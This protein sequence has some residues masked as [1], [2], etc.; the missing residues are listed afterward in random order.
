MAANERSF[1]ARVASA[2]VRTLSQL[3]RQPTRE[4][5]RILRIYFGDK[6]YQRLHGLALQ[7][8]DVRGEVK[9]LGNV[10]VLHGMLGGELTWFPPGG[11]GRDIWMNLWRIVRG[12][13]QYCQLKREGQSER[14]DIRATGLLQRYY[15]ELLLSLSR[16]WNVRPFWFDWRKDIRLSAS[17]L[18]SQIRNWFD[19]GQPVHLVAHS[20]GGLVARAFI[21]E[22]RT[23]WLGMAE[24]GAKLIMLGTPNFGSFSAL[25][26]LTGT[27]SMVR[28]VAKLDLCHSL[29]QIRAIASSFPGV[30][31]MLPWPEA[32][33]EVEAVYNSKNWDAL[34]DVSTEALANSLKFQEWLSD[35]IDP[36]RMIY[37]A[38]CNKPTANRLADPQAFW[39]SDFVGASNTALYGFTADGDGTVPHQLGFQKQGR[40]LFKDVY[41][42]EE[43]HGS[44]PLNHR[45][46]KAIDEILEEGGTQVL[47]RDPPS[48]RTA[49]DEEEL[50]KEWR[51][52]REPDLVDPDMAWS[53]DTPARTGSRKSSPHLVAAQR[54][55]DARMRSPHSNEPNSRAMRAI[56]NIRNRTRTATSL[57]SIPASNDERKVES[58][59]TRSFLYAEETD[60]RAQAMAEAA[61][62]RPSIEIGLVHAPIESL[63]YAS[64]P[65][66]EDLAVDCIS[67]GHY[68]GVLPQGAESKLDEAI[69]R[70]LLRRAGQPLPGDLPERDRVL[71]QYTERGILQGRL[72]QPFFLSDPRNH[73]NGTERLIVL[74]GMGVPGQ[75][76]IPELTVLVRELCWSLGQ[77]DKKHLL[78]VLI[79]GGVGNLSTEDAILGWM[80]GLVQALTGS[81]ELPNRRLQRVTFIEFDPRRLPSLNRAIHNAVTTFEESLEIK[82]RELDQAALTKLLDEAEK[83]EITRLR[84]RWLESEPHQQ[85]VPTRISVQ[86]VGDTYTFGAIT[87]DASIPQRNIPLDTR[88]VDDANRQLARATE[89]FEQWQQGR[90]LERLL[91]PRDF[92]PQMATGAP[93]VI[94]LDR[95]TA[96]LH[97]ELL[98]QPDPLDHDEPDRSSATS[99]KQESFLGTARGLTRQFRTAF[100]PPPEPPPPPRLVLRVLVIADPAEDARLPGAEREGVEVADLIES[101][102]TVFARQTMNR[103]YVERLFGPFEATWDNVLKKLLLEKWDVLHFAGHCFFDAKEPIRSGWIFGAKDRKVLTANEFNRIDS[104]PKFVFSN[105]CESGLMPQQAETADSSM[106]PSFAEAFFQRGVANF[107]CTAWP[108]DDAAACAFAKRL[109]SALLGLQEPD[110]ARP[111]PMHEAMRLARCEI[112]MFGGHTWGAYQH[113]GN[114]NFRLFDADSFPS[115]PPKESRE[116]RSKHDTTGSMRSSRTKARR[117]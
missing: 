11:A 3:L 47:P 66:R 54:A 77:L 2:D 104:V 88:L 102:N 9:L 5:E 73:G 112:A 113:Y 67:V 22:Y 65:G 94:V 55:G 107:V 92:R 75:F 82:Y 76:G 18:E 10:V 20:M 114:P 17:L 100:A 24:A 68:I 101:F 89:P 12:R 42:V 58:L 56:G 85:L 13:F 59:V 41:F 27:E 50:K 61:I 83:Q 46:I 117:H 71:T 52:T 48:V 28:L 15:G 87:A 116:A 57:K 99:F 84:K 111:K 7:A 109:Y 49:V 80:R 32:A 97:W 39:Q 38:G 105:A 35:A 31:Q 25:Q 106:A 40:Q 51:R 29:P 63:N 30:Y 64:P 37:I 21:K 4:E 23:R 33:P 8:S 78:T 45:V 14:H 96:R 115:E 62:E 79:G 26:V 60:A 72:G 95:T 34:P 86:L 74:A 108:I 70:E 1:I 81:A 91:I 19:G 90:F 98:A 93:L 16:R 43:E 110:P 44:L 53:E 36:D 6:H 69:S 103:V